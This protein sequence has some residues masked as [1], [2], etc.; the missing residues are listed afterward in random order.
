MSYSLVIASQQ[1]DRDNGQVHALGQRF[2]RKQTFKSLLETEDLGDPL[3]SATDSAYEVEDCFQAVDFLSALPHELALHVLSFIDNCRDMHSVTQVSRKWHELAQNNDVW[4][5]VY[6]RAFPGEQVNVDAYLARRSMLLQ[7]IGTVELVKPCEQQVGSRRSS[8]RSFAEN[9][10][11]PPQTLFKQAA[12]SSRGLL[13]SSANLNGSSEL[14]PVSPTSRAGS[15]HTPLV[16]RRSPALSD[17]PCSPVLS[18]IAADQNL[19]PSRVT[20]S[21]SSLSIKTISSTESLYPNF[22]VPG[23]NI[24]DWRDLFRQRL[25]LESNWR[26]GVLTSTTIEGHEDSV[27]CIQFDGNRL[28]SGSRD[29]KIKIW[30]MHSKACERTLSGHEGSVLCL[31]YNGKYLVS[32]SSDATAIIWDLE[33]GSILKVLRGHRAPVLDIRFE[34]DYIVTCSKDCTIRVWSLPDGAFLRE[35]RGHNAAVNAVHLHGTTLVSASGDCLVKLWDITS[36]ACIRDFS[37]HTR[38]LACVQFDGDLVVSGS[39]DKT[40]RVWKASTGECLNVFEDHS[41]LVR[42]LCFNKQRV[43]SGSYDQHIRVWNLQTGSLELQIKDAHS[44]WVFHVQM[45]PTR[46]VSASQ[47]RK[48]TIWDF[49]SNVADYQTFIPSF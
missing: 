19:G 24:V 36:G 48:I 10:C 47:D 44:S 12:V 11:K 34:G 45:D 29:R 2:S 40:I 41:D 28:V 6:S 9:S 8:N 16:A 20:A 14:E 15:F 38:G 35:L 26:H 7:T 4:C 27:Y 31:Q 21:R 3:N 13:T 25:Q 1:G 39:N 22:G 30:N 32:G 46:I 42:T 17:A 5:S 18:G 23:V 33:K 37:G 43:V 49:T